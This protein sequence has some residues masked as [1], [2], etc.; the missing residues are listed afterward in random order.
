MS[1]K[2]IFVIIDGNAIVHRAYHALPPLTTKDGTLINAAYGFTSVLLK[3]IK[4]LKPQYLAVTFDL[5]GK[6]FRHDAFPAYKAQRKPKPQEFYDQFDFVKQVVRAFRIPVVEKTG[7]EA[8]DMIGTLATRAEKELEDA[9]MVIVTGD[10]DTLQLVNDRIHV[11]SLK[12]GV[13]DL[14]RYDPAAVHARYGL[15]PDQ[16]IDFKSLRGDPS[17]N[18]PGVKGIG[19]KTAADLIKTFGSLEVLYR[20]LDKQHPKIQKLSS[21]LR[22]RLASGKAEAKLSKKLSTIVRDVPLKIHPRDCRLVPYAERE[23]IDLFQKLEFRSLLNRLPEQKSQSAFF[24]DRESPAIEKKRDHPHQRYTLVADPKTF[25]A[26]LT[27]L[28]KHNMFALDTETTSLDPIQAELLGMSIAWKSGEAYYIAVQLEQTQPAAWKS[29]IQMLENPRIKKIGHHIKYDLNVLNR[30]GIDLQGIFF[31]S[32][33]ASYLLHPGE[34]QNSLDACAFSEFGYRMMPI[35]DLIGPN[36]KGQKNMKDVPLEDVAWY[37]SEDADWTWRLYKIYEKK[38]RDQTLWSLFQKIEMPLVPILAQMEQHG[39][40]IDVTFLGRLSKQFHKQLQTIEKKIYKVAGKKFNILSPIQLRDILFKK[41]KLSTEELSKTKTGISTAAAQLDKLRGKHPI[42]DLIGQYREFSKLISTYVDALPSL[43]NPQTGRVHTSYNQT[44]AAT[45]RL[46]SSD[47]NLQNIPIRTVEGREI[48]KAF[49]AP[50]GTTYL[51]ADYSQLELRI[52][53]SLARDEK[54]MEIFKNREDIH[55]RTAAEI[56][57]IPPSKVTPEM[58]RAAKAV[59]FGVI[60]GQG[61]YGLAQGAEIPREEARTFI[62]SYFTLFSGIKAYL[63]QT[64]ALA[65]KVGYVETLFGR[66]RPIPEIQSGVMQIRRA[67]ERMAINMPIQGTAADLMKLAM[68]EMAQLL[69]KISP[70]T[71]MILQVHDEL[72][73]EVPPADV[74]KVSRVVKEIMEHITD[75]DV[76]LEVD[77]HAGKN[78]GEAHPLKG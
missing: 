8:D 70:K 67:A 37:A 51:M 68:I 58:R 2:E 54:M 17:D 26:F 41:L 25:Q 72:V 36:G 39:V 13:S 11:L 63:E 30:H 16:M 42:V 56:H 45:G 5:P 12:R 61:V 43:V 14:V 57:H 21:S 60:Y 76:P 24:L 69:P 32:M 49:I 77:L 64:K 20:A 62:E 10:M 66:R 75:L 6:T 52:V 3:T 55:T 65:K 34:R 23:V 19:E 59:N 71:H 73:F 27:K 74:V 47:P 1:K 35:T 46:S 15:R 40:L 33:I 18:I 7:F 22:E 78:W 31:D 53:A 29:L 44:I 48:R 9:Q 4:D 50:R 38:L 28:K